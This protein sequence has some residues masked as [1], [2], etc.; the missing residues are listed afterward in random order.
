VAASVAAAA[1]GARTTTS[2]TTEPWARA[3]ARV[4]GGA[5]VALQQRSARALVAHA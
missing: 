4:P 5:R 3:V 1:T 2:A